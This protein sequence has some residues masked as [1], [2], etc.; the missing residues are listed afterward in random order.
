M[1]NSTEDHKDLIIAFLGGA[2]AGGSLAYFLQSDK[3]KEFISDASEATKEKVKEGKELLQQTEAE[4]LEK[5][6]HA[7]DQLDVDGAVEK[8]KEALNVNKKSS[9]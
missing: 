3:G 6:N 1:S 8:G 9:K 7:I 2:L 5:F 4:I